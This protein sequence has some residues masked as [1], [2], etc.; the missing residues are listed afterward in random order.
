MAGPSIRLGDAELAAIA[1]RGVPIPRYDRSRLRPR[2]AHVGV[3]GFHRAHLA[4][5]VHELAQD[6]GDWGI[7]G[8]GLLAQDAGIADALRTQDHLYT[9]VEKGAGEPSAQVIGSIVDFVHAPPDR[10]EAA[11]AVIASP[12]TRILSL[13]VTEAGYA[14][15]ADGDGPTTFDRIATGL[16][17]RRDGA[18]GPLTVLSCDNLPGNGHA[19]RRATLAAAARHDAE[20]P[21]WIEEHC[22]F[23]NSMVDR[24][25]PATAPA[26]RAW[27]LEHTGIQ[28][29]WP[30][31]AEPFRQWVLED[32]FA[33]SRPAFEAVG[34]LLSDRVGDWELYKLRLLNA[35]HS[36]MAYLA[37][38][39]GLELV[40][41]AMAVPD[42]ARFLQGLLLEEA[43]P[44]L[45]AIPGHPRERYAATVLGRFANPGVH[46]QIARLCIDGSAKFPTFLLPTVERQ[47]GQDGPIGRAATALAGWARY[48]GVVPVADQAPDASAAAARHHAGRALSDPLA[49]LDF[50]AVFPA[51]L[52]ESERFRAAFAAGYRVVSEDGPLAALAAAGR[53]HRAPERA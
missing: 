21:A 22:T 35:G 25:T 24:I 18:A 27:L 8:L 19:T 45:D 23:P 40:H 16:A 11:T 29:A 28:D 14:E 36:A 42:V 38:L 50:D 30:V 49:F 51:A 15:P 52:R 12:D 48:L 3:G 2:I 4:G 13:T 41:E 17:G 26:D 34:A 9:L 31:V 39:A 10:G 33:G 46:D 43:A 6:G 7:R 32:D 37:A 1:R 53:G 20:L 44:T 47:L 5:Y